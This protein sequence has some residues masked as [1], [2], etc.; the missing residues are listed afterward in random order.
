M[1]TL[2]IIIHLQ[3]LQK[4]NYFNPQ[5]HF[6]CIALMKFELWCAV[7]SE[8]WLL[9]FIYIYIYIYMHTHI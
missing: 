8:L 6:E 1:Q 9:G 4:K 5:E 3:I 2:K 7:F